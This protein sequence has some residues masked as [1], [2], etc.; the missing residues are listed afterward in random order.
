MPLTNV[1]KIWYI[2]RHKSQS[3]VFT[4][5]QLVRPKHETGKALRQI[6]LVGSYPPRQCGI[7]T[8]TNDLYRAM[9]DI[10]E[11]MKIVVEPS[12][13]VPLASLLEKKVEVAGKRAA[14]LLSGGN[15]SLDA[16][17]WS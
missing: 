5:K 9:R 3:G 1:F 10:W 12:A 2:Y 14:I 11:R 7:A 16:L 6:A 15:V 13:S 4:E 17:P 8:F